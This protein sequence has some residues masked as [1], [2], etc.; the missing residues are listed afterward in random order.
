MGLV[1]DR[2]F[3]HTGTDLHT[4]IAE[5]A[6]V[7]RPQLTLLD[8]T[9]AL[10]TGGPTGPGKVQELHTV[11]AGTNMLAVDVYTTTIV[12]WYNRSVTAHSVKHLALAAELGIGEID[13]KK[14]SIVKESV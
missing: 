4:A 5:L 3:F 11:I 10:V 12:P 6:T 14:L 13:E 7:I 2:T 1:W 8:A 9:H